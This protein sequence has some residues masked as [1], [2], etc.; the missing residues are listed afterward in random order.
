MAGIID[1]GGKESMKE[2]LLGFSQAE[3]QAVARRK[4]LLDAH[5]GEIRYHI[6]LRSDQSY[7]EMVLAA[8]ILAFIA[9]TGFG[10]LAQFSS[11]VTTSLF[12]TA[13]TGMILHACPL[14]GLD[15]GVWGWMN[16][17]APKMQAL[18]IGVALT[19]AS[20]SMSGLAGL[21]AGLLAV[22]GIVGFAFAGSIKPFTKM[23]P[24]TVLIIVM[25][26]CSRA[27][28]APFLG[29]GISATGLAVGFIAGIASWVAASGLRD[30]IASLQVWC[31]GA[32]IGWLVRVASLSLPTP[33]ALGMITL[34][35]PCTVILLRSLAFRGNFAPLLCAVI[36]IHLGTACFGNE[37][38][39]EPVAPQILLVVL[40]F[41]LL[42][43]ASYRQAVAALERFPRSTYRSDPQCLSASLDHAWEHP[44]KIDAA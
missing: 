17:L 36:F 43:M 40:E 33:I 28:L 14:K 12:I 10:H 1:S 11:P 25:M 27:H 16:K 4:P 8:I 38:I 18:A 19:V 3:A 5:R 7:R 31:G 13:V 6:A 32:A 24:V 41:C 15:Q 22:S 34:L 9:G 20:C 29:Q 26:I 39:L 42:G 44:V 23:I 37:K 2:P 21:K 30:E 35:I